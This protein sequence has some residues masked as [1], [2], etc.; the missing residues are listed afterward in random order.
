MSDAGGHGGPEEASHLGRPD[1]RGG[2]YEARVELKNER[3]WISRKGPQQGR[4][5]LKG[6]HGD[7]PLRGCRPFGQRRVQVVPWGAAVDKAGEVGRDL[8]TE[9]LGCQVWTFGFYLQKMEIYGRIF[10]HVARWPV[11]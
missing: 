2:P 10:E 4:A 7:G 9:G 11:L 8:V 6:R 3:S 1:G 5:W